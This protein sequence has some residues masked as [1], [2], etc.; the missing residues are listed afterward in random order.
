ME[1]PRAIIH[2]PLRQGGKARRAAAGPWAALAI[3]ESGLR[4]SQQ[5]L[6]KASPQNKLGKPLPTPVTRQL[7]CRLRIP[8][9]M[10]TERRRLGPLQN[11]RKRRL[12]AELPQGRNVLMAEA[13]LLLGPPSKPLGVY[14]P[15][16]ERHTLVTDR[17]PSAPEQVWT[18]QNLP[19]WRQ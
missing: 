18:S 9:L 15:Q 8:L 6:P 19:L 17:P 11:L 12:V 7:Q 2:S 10:V 3:S 14:A 16:R 4:R 13:P 1:S 5:R